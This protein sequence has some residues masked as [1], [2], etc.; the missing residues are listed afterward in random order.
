V[1]ERI[2]FRLAVL[3]VMPLGGRMVALGVALQIVSALMPV[4]FIVATSAVV[5]RVPGAVHAG[6]DSPEWRS[7]RNTLIVAGLLF[8]AQQ[9][10]S[11]L[12]FTAQFMLA[13]RVDDHLRERAAAASF[14]RSASRRSRSP[15]STTRSPI[16]RTRNVAR[17]SRRDPRVGAR[18]C[19]SRCISSGQ[20]RRR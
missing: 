14:A 4:A 13:W 12:Q 18:S 5:G 17:G 3:R 8:V 19:C 16:S 10:I 2:R 15:T 20:L 6:L 9:V 7:L 11:P 1:R